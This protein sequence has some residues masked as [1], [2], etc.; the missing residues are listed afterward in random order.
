MI[1]PENVCPLRRTVMQS[2]EANTF[3]GR[4]EFTSYLGAF[5]EVLVSVGGEKIRALRNSEDASFE[6][7]EKVSRRLPRALLLPA[8][9]PTPDLADRRWSGRS[10]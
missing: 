8:S 5:S 2:H 9:D 6:V 7:D 10:L 4:V 1:K 3:A